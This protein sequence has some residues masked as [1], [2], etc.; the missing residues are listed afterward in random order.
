[1]K[2]VLTL[3]LTTLIKYSN[4]VAL[5]GLC[6]RLVVAP[7]DLLH[8]VCIEVL[9]NFVYGINSG[10]KLIFLLSADIEDS[11]GVLAPLGLD[12]VPYS[13][14]GVELATLWREELAGKP[15]VIKLVFD[16]LAV[17]DREV[18]HDHDTPVKGVDLLKLLDE[19]QE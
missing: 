7:G 16:Y 15:F 9:S 5:E 10:N 2:F 3:N 6:H 14:N 1:M 4:N 8:E 13:F 17:M 11:K 19:R 12:E 18:V